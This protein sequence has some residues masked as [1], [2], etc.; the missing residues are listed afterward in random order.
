MKS[1]WS[2][3]K[4][5]NPAGALSGYV[6][7]GAPLVAGF[8][9]AALVLLIVSPGVTTNVPLIGPVMVTMVTSAALLVFSIR[10]GFW[11]V[12]YW[13]TPAERLMW[14]PA[15]VVADLPLQRQ[16]QLL[17]GRMLEFGKLRRRAEHLFQVG[18]FVFL[19]A[20]ALL[21]AP[22]QWHA[23]GT[24][25]RWAA[26]SV[27]GLAA[28]VH[29]LWSAGNW[30]HNRNARVYNRLKTRS[31][32]SGD[33]PARRA[34]RVARRD[35]RLV[36]YLVMLWPP[37][38]DAEIPVPAK[39]DG[40][41]LK[42]LRWPAPAT[43]AQASGAAARAPASERGQDQA[44]T[45]T[46]AAGVAAAGTDLAAAIDEPRR[47]DVERLGDPAS[48]W[49]HIRGPD[50]SVYE[51]VASGS[52]ATDLL[53]TLVMLPGG[54]RV[55]LATQRWVLPRWEGEA[56]P[57]GVPRIWAIKPGFVVN[58]RRSCAELAVVD[59]LRRE[60][61]DGVWVS[62]FAGNW[63]RRDW[64]PTPAFRS[65]REAAAPDWAAQV[66]E[67]LRQA[68]GGTLSG[69]FNVFAWRAPGDIRFIEVKMGSDPIQATQRTF[70]QMA[71]RYHRP[72][73]FMI[74]EVA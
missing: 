33:R 23:S 45:A 43:E 2:E 3:P 38:R 30:R 36:R 11:A 55:A 14:D 61:W 28:L 46:A 65:P 4:D 20:V 9:L 16:R 40:D 44:R 73:Q 19:V 52:Q 41:S 13:T 1:L 24:D 6:G 26:A 31:N 69:F 59:R 64:F 56:D 58:G 12:S 8:E 32:G 49:Q 63:V 18:I 72:E 34:A 29:L 27:A 15:A 21:L 53:A 17:A 42:G 7:A 47:S 37:A 54:E 48:R 74:V 22:D 39:P 60:G 70:L 10:Y 71:L 62:A 57:V 35:D 25:W 51:L 66:F 68:H 50:A 67:K 5:P